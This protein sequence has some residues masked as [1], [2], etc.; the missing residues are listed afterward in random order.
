MCRIF[1]RL[2]VVALVLLFGWCAPVSAQGLDVDVNHDGIVTSLDVDTVTDHINTYGNN[3]DTFGDFLAVFGS[4]DDSDLQDEIESE[5]PTEIMRV[6]GLYLPS[7]ADIDRTWHH[8]AWARN[9]VSGNGS[10]TPLDVLLIIDY[11]NSE[12]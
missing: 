8:V 12:R 6:L 9:D 1:A 5:G 2:V 7:S 11:I 10:I 3:T 4:Y